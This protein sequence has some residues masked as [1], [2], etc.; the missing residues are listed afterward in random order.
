MSQQNLIKGCLEVRRGSSN[1]PELPSVVICE[2]PEPEG[3]FKEGA[4][5]YVVWDLDRRGNPSYGYYTQT[6]KVALL[7]FKSRTTR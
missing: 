3:G 7:S 6:L 5:R 4:D 2:L 1:E